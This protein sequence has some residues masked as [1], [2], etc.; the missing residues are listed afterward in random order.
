MQYDLAA[1][2]VLEYPVVAVPVGH[3]E[4]AGL[5]HGHGARLAEVLLVVA[6]DEPRGTTRFRK[7]IYWGYIVN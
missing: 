6:R 4:L 1:R 7:K 3:E 2:G 5:H